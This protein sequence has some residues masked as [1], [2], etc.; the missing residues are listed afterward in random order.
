MDLEVIF[1]QIRWHLEANLLPAPGML[2][3]WDQRVERL[4]SVCHPDL[5]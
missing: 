2:I 5:R 3:R 4:S 1:D